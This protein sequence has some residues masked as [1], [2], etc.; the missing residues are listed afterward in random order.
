LRKIQHAL[1]HAIQNLLSHMGF[2]RILVFV[3]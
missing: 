2:T 1:L 3:Q